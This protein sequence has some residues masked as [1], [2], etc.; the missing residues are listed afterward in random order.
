MK[1]DTLSPVWNELWRIKNVPSNAEL[2]VDVLDKDEGQPH[3]D[4]VGKFKTTVTPG[5]K[6][7]EITHPILPNSRGT[8]WIKARSQKIYF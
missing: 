4:Y 6:E 3:D 8:F 7:I 2:V 1:P 5:A